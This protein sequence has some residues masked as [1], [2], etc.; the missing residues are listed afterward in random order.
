[1]KKLVVLVIFCSGIAIQGVGQVIDITSFFKASEIQGKVLLSWQI[2]SGSTCNGIQIYRGTD[3]TQLAQV[4]EIIG[5]CGSVTEPVDYTFV[6][7]KLNENNTYYYRLEFGTQG[8]SEII[9]VTVEGIFSN[10]SQVRPNPISESGKIV[11]TKNSVQNHT[12][13]LYNKHGK[14]VLEKTSTENSFDINALGLKNGVY[15]YTITADNNTLIARE[16][17]LIHH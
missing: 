7:E 4:G 10:T 3:S 16:K 12:L 15:V 6:D 8:F 9:S 13:T 14:K 11:F 1:M 2:V 5:V 17:L